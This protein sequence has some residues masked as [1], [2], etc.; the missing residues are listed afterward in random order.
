MNDAC[1]DCGVTLSARTAN[2]RRSSHTTGRCKPCYEAA[3]RAAL[4]AR[5]R[6]S[7]RCRSC[8]KP[9]T[10]A[11]P[12]GQCRRCCTREANRD[13][14]MRARKAVTMRRRCA[15]P[16]YRAHLSRRIKAATAS[17]EAR[18]RPAAAG[19]MNRGRVGNAL[20]PEHRAKIA[21][22]VAAHR[23]RKR[24][25][26]EEAAVIAA[27]TPFERKLRLIA[28]GKARIIEV[29]NLRRADPAMT[30][31]GVASGMW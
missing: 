29:P 5:P 20:S 13:P 26:S 31:G 12:T 18:A 23:Q 2:R 24:L 14:E 15:D 10:I 8:E 11:R 27:L 6:P 16:A 17:P 28:Q 22:G 7:F 3:R 19:R 4:A 30:L 21:A 1:A 25:L 9:L